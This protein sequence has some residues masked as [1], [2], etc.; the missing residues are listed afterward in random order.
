MELYTEHQSGI[1]KYYS[2]ETVIQTVIDEWKLI[3]SE[4]KIGGVIFMDHK[5]AFEIIDRERLLEKIY[6]YGMRERVLEWFKLY[7]NNRKQ[8]V[9]FNH[10]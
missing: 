10:T 6:Q 1:R 8:Q 2:C 5:K 4:E 3:V 9:R 7:L